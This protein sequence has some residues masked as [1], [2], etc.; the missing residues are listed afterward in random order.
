MHC[1]L[2]SLLVFSGFT[3]TDL[4]LCYKYSKV[5]YCNPYVSACCILSL[6]FTLFA[7]CIAFVGFNSLTDFAFRWSSRFIRKLRMRRAVAVA[8]GVAAALLLP[9]LLFCELLAQ[10]KTE[11]SN[12]FWVL[13][14][15]FDDVKDF[16]G[17][18]L[19]LL[20]HS[21]YSSKVA[22]LEK[23]QVENVNHN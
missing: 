19:G 17:F 7:L 22:F 11:S 23:P 9:V 4:S 3:S 5:C 16:F 13:G 2:V 12:K 18:F 14:L 1:K 15:G 8:A 10:N 6:H 21:A 20:L